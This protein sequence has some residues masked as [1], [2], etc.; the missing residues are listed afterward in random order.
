MS[1]SSVGLKTKLKEI[2]GL[3]TLDSNKPEQAVDDDKDH[4]VMAVQ[5]TEFLCGGIAIGVSISHK[6]CDGTTVAQFLQAWSQ[7]ANA[8]EASEKVASSLPPN[9]EASLLFP[10]M[11][12]EFDMNDIIGEKNFT[13]KRFLFN[14][15]SLCRL[16]E[17]I[18]S[19]CSFR[20]TR[21][22]TVTTLIWK[23]AME[24][25][26]TTETSHKS[27]S[28]IVHAVNIRGR[29]LTPLPNNSFGETSHSLIT[30]LLNC[31][32]F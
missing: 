30:C 18:A 9:M 25:A 21:V 2:K 24:A 29:M 26:R 19:D 14:G 15:D 5:V 6:V 27:K 3:L 13:T 4:L 7:K 12:I 10:P 28:L 31:E 8:E 32:C 23:A 1:S 17:K 11:G 20:P 16:Q 22:E